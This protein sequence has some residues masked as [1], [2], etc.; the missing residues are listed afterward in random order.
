MTNGKTNIGSWLGSV[1]LFFFFLLMG[2]FWSQ[3]SN[4]RID[5]GSITIEQV[6]EI[7]HSAALNVH[8]DLSNPVITLVSCD[9]NCLKVYN[10][11]PDIWFSNHATKQEF[12]NAVLKLITF[13]PALSEFHLLSMQSSSKGDYPLIS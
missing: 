2:L 6:T 4:P 10:A 8:Y 9:I 1:L 13:K 12:K 3:D 11:R 5:I 7:N